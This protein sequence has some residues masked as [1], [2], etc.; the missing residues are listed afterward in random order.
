VEAIDNKVIGALNR[1]S[2]YASAA[3]RANGVSWRL[4]AAC[5]SADPE[6]FFPL[7]GSG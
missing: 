1:V 2:A 7:A 5:R 6:L 4:A 3:R